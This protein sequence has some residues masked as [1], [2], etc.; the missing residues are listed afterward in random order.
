L[1][2]IAIAA[3]FVVVIVAG[4]IAMRASSAQVRDFVMEEEDQI[5]KDDDG[6][7]TEAG[8]DAGRDAEP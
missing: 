8:T 3:V 6:V 4:W 7:I 1:A 2:G 5:K